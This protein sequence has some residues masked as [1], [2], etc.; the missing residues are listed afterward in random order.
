M[1]THRS[2]YDHSENGN[3]HEFSP[4]TESPM[5]RS[6]NKLFDFQVEGLNFV[7]KNWFEKRNSVLCDSKEMG[8]TIESIAVLE[9]LSKIY[10]SWGPFVVVCPY[11]SVNHW[12]NEFENWTEFRVVCLTDLKDTNELVKKY[13]MFHHVDEEN[14]LDIDN[15]IFDVLIVSYES[16]PRQISFVNKFNFMFAVFDDA[17]KIKN[18]EANI[19]QNCM[20]IKAHRKLLLTGDLDQFNS[21]E[22]WSFLH[23]VSPSKFADYE[24]FEQKYKSQKYQDEIKKRFLVRNKSDINIESSE[25]EENIVESEMTNLQRDFAQTVVKNH[26]VTLPDISASKMKIN[27]FL[28][29]IHKILCHPFLVPELES[30]CL[31]QY[32]E[33]NGISKNSQLDT[34]N[35]MNSIITSSGKMILFDKLIHKLKE[36]KHK[37]LV[38]SSMKKMLDIIEN[39]LILKEYLYERL[40]GSYSLNKRAF[41]IERFQ[42]FDDVFIILLSPESGGIGVDLTGA[43]TV[44][45]Y[46]GE[47]DPRNDIFA[48]SSIHE[49][50]KSKSINVIRLTT[51]GCYESEVLLN[52]LSSLNFESNNQESFDLFDE[53]KA[54]ENNEE[55]ILKSKKKIQMILRKSCY[56]IFYDNPDEI[57][58]FMTQDIEKILEN[59]LHSKEEIQRIQSKSTRIENRALN[60]ENFWDD[61]LQ[62]DSSYE[63]DDFDFNT[64]IKPRTNRKEEVRDEDEYDF[65]N[66][67]PN[68]PNEQSSSSS[69][70]DSS[71]SFSEDE[72]SDDEDQSSNLFDLPDLEGKSTNLPS[73]DTNYSSELYTITALNQSLF[74]YEK[75]GSKSEL[76]MPKFTPDSSDIEAVDSSDEMNELKST[77]AELSDSI[78]MKIFTESLDIVRKHGIAG[79]RLFTSETMVEIGKSLVVL[80]FSRLSK[81]EMKKYKGYIHQHIPKMSKQILKTPYKEMN[82]EEFISSLFEGNELQIIEDC[83]HFDKIYRVALFV[84]TEK[85]PEKFSF[86]PEMPTPLGWTAADDFILLTASPLFEDV[87]KIADDERLP[88]KNVSKSFK[89]F[90]KWIKERVELI[91]NETAIVVP[92]DFSVYSRKKGNLV[93]KK[94]CDVK[95]FKNLNYHVFC[96]ERLPI[97]FQKKLLRV[98]YLYGFPKMMEFR[99]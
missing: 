88:F 63:V 75:Q 61:F 74:P 57:D 22:I 81:K 43:D 76:I 92:P 44:V 51:S 99:R 3:E 42:K 23:F 31:A 68:D 28:T 49:D 67:D 80:A 97:S 96:P 36:E 85:L 52:D 89:S 6:F 69:S 79:A 46:D 50:N 54:T 10:L 2:E 16:L 29:S 65:N 93:P 98:L 15:V 47:Y 38:F 4:F 53:N 18:Y 8:R 58:I 70:S 7:I 60:K 35:E 59:R 90:K 45:I 37:I 39:Y 78:V 20:S 66:K 84:S 1:Q 11:S 40:D 14:K 17:Q 87:S 71:F 55:A 9:Y 5:Y 64:G 27:N 41:S 24:K 94:F 72:N 26:L 13:L 34:I 56:H 95:I 82:D 12:I 21:V 91:V 48:Q 73:N 33:L 86:A 62:S 30:E 25:N 19:Y 83:F 32:K 77:T